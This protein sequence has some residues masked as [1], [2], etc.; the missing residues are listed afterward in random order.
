MLRA[1]F[2]P[3]LRPNA[4]QKREDDGWRRGFAALGAGNGGSQTVRIRHV[5]DGTPSVVP[6]AYT[7]ARVDGERARRGRMRSP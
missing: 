6:V 5:V 7:V 2:A 4:S 1:N 3:T